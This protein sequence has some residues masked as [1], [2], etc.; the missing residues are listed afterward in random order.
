VFHLL[1]NKFY[2][3]IFRNLQVYIFFTL[4][5]GARKRNQFGRIPLHYAVDKSQSKLSA[6]VI[7]LLLAAYPKGSSESANDGIIILIFNV[8][9]FC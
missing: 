3:I 5:E 7:K 6:E 1:H 2:H 8:N 4:V 9:E